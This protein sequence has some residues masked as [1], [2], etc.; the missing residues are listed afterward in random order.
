VKIKAQ[1][2]TD[3]RTYGSVT[4]KDVAEA[5]EAQHKIKVDRRKISL[6]EPIRTFGT[7]ILDVK[8]YADISGKITVAVTE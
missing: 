6:N 7:Y 5:L 2:G 1:G 3:G 8:L 4:A